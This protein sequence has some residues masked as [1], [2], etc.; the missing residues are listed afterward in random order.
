MIFHS[1]LSQEK[2]ETQEKEGGGGR[3]RAFSPLTVIYLFIYFTQKWEC[4]SGAPELTKAQVASGS[5]S[6]TVELQVLGRTCG[7]LWAS[8]CPQHL[9]RLL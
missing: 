3:L 9:L 4:I 2:G 8:S 5:A 6:G 7:V 1:C